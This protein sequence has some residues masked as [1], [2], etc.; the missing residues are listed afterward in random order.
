M[1]AAV[2]RRPFMK[3]APGGARFKFT[4][5]R[6]YNELQHSEFSHSDSAGR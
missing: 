3:C 1:V 4:V 6:S 5:P 2:M